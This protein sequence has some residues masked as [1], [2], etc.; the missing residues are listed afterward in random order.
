MERFVKRV[1]RKELASKIDPFLPL[2][3]AQVLFQELS[4][5]PQNRLTQLLSCLDAPRVTPFRE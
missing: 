1:M 4:A 3:S 2:L 5:G